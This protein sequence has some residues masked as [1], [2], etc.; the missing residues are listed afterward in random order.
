MPNQ[1]L[2]REIIEAAISGYETQKTQIE[3]QIAD[4][5]S[6]LSGS[7]SSSSLATGRRGK[8]PAATRKRMVEGQQRRWAKVRGE[9]SVSNAPAKKKAGRK[10]RVMSEEGRAAI[11]AA[12]RKRW[13]A[14]K[15]AGEGMAKTRKKKA[16]DKA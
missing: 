1:Q 13:A 14:K 9:S 16:T 2:T 4:L 12:Q 5:R 10:K 11:A 15:D 3:I 7:S 6:M 8:R